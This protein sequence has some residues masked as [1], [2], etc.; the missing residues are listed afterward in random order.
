MKSRSLKNKA[1]TTLIIGLLSFIAVKAESDTLNLGDPYDIDV[2]ESNEAIVFNFNDTLTIL[3]KENPTTGFVWFINIPDDYKD[4][5]SITSNTY[6][7]D[8]A[9][10][11]MKRGQK[12]VGGR[13]QIVLTTLAPGKAIVQL[14]NAKRSKFEGFDKDV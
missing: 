9:T 4:L 2:I 7:S 5:V 14:A 13:R 12:G 11:I 8:V 10:N 1:I 6:K 3:A